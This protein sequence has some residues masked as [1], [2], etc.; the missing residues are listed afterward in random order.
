MLFDVNYDTITASSGTTSTGLE[1]LLDSNYDTIRGRSTLDTAPFFYLDTTTNFLDRSVP[2][3]IQQGGVRFY[4]KLVLK[5][6]VR[7]EGRYQK[8]H[9]L[10]LLCNGP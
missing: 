10:S 5:L 1:M 9:Q 2:D 4:K 3:Q 7:R 8:T 6:T